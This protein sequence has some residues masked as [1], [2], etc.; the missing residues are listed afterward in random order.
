MFHLQEGEGLGEVDR[1]WYLGEVLANAV[2]HDAP[3]G[4]GDVRLVRH[5]AP[6]LSASRSCS[7]ESFMK[8]GSEKNI[9][10]QTF[11]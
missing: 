1:D 9:N 3:Q 7:G 8:L 2:L 4:E 11:V 10:K 6:S 5:T